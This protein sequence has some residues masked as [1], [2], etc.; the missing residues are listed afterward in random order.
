MLMERK[1]QP[2]NYHIFPIFFLP[3]MKAFK[4]IIINQKSFQENCNLFVFA[5]FM[6]S[7]STANLQ[8]KSLAYS[9]DAPQ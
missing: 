8:V 9:S 1:V 6:A 2:S 5:A 3:N 4:T 7:L